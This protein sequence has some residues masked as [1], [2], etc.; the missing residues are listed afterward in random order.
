VLAIGLPGILVVAAT[1]PVDLADSL[2][3]Q[4]H[5]PVKFAYGTLARCGCCPCWAR[6]GRR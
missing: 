2:V 1:D 4:L 6:S 5:L 3:Q